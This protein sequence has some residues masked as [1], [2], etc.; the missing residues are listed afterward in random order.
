M[1]NFEPRKI[2]LMTS[3][4]VPLLSFASPSWLTL[5]G[6]G[7]S[8][9]VLWLMPW[10]LEEG[11][12]SGVVAALAM[13][14]MM[15][16]ILIDGPSHI[17]ALA[18][19]AFWWGRLGMRNIKIEGSFNFGLLAFLGSFILGL[20]FW[21]QVWLMNLGGSDSINSWALQS[22]LAQSFLTGLLGPIICSWLVLFLRKR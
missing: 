19:L 8:W 1:M 7:P 12:R 9:T 21:F 20:T 22:L 3:I 16:G 10:A 15:D 18:V 13:G 2:V 6:I 17:P 14:L 11:W 4:L 5:S